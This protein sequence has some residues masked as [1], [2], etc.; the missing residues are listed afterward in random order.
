[1]FKRGVAH[2]LPEVVL[3]RYVL[4]VSE[5]WFIF[6]ALFVGSVLALW[7]A[8]PDAA[9][10]NETIGLLAIIFNCAVVFSLI[11]AF[12]SLVLFGA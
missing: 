1:M 10:E 8:F 3:Q 4:N 6:S 11:S 9:G 7:D 2:A 5:L 12:S